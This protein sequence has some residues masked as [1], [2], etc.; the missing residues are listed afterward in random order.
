MNK[1]HRKGTLMSEKFN[2]QELPLSVMNRALDIYNEPREETLAAA[3]Q[4][5]LSAE[6]RKDVTGPY[7]PFAQA[8]A[9]YLSLSG[10]W[11]EEDGE[12]K[13]EN[14]YAVVLSKGLL[15]GD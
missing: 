12:F 4:A 3:T 14:G 2:I 15:F 11:N 6:G 10:A 13:G 5:L 1:Q 8:V 7:T 9:E